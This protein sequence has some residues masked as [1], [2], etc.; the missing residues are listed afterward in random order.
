MWYHVFV[1]TLTGAKTFPVYWKEADWVEPSI[2]NFVEPPVGQFFTSIRMFE[3][4]I[5][6]VRSGTISL[7]NNR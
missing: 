3:K 4:Y 5:A 7:R 2:Q 6:A 1:I